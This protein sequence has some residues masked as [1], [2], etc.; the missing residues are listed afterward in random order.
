MKESELK[1]VL[2]VVRV[3]DLKITESQWGGLKERIL[4]LSEPFFENEVI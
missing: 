3:D 4:T 2:F 1:T